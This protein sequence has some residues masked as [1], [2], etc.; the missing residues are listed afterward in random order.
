MITR[1]RNHLRRWA[2][3][4]L[5]VWLFGVFAGVANACVLGG[6]LDHDAGPAVVQH[7]SSQGQQGDGGT[8]D[9]KNC[10]QFCDQSSS[11]V[12]SQVKTLDQVVMS[13]IPVGFA[14]MALPVVPALRLPRNAAP[15]RNSAPA[16]PIAF[17]RLTL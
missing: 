11:A 1:H 4:M 2:S 10:L 5:L 12:P 16:I 17:L 3:R 15:P 9:E 6:A 14:T 7:S 8:A 13:A